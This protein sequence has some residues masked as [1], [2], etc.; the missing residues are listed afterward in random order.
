M[1]ILSKSLFW[2]TA[3]LLLAGCSDKHGATPA[4][5]STAGAATQSARDIRM[6]GMMVAIFG[7]QFRAASNDA[8]AQMPDPENRQRSRSFVIKPITSSTL[9]GGETVLV[10]SGAV[11]DEQGNPEVAHAIG[12]LLSIYFLRSVEGAW[13]VTRKLENI[14]SLGSYGSIG[15]VQ[16]T[17]LGQ[18][19]TGMV[20]LNSGSGQGE[21]VTFMSIFDLTAKDIH[22]LA[23]DPIKLQSSN[24]GDCA[25]ERA[26]CWHVSGAWSFEPGDDPDAYADLVIHFTGKRTVTTSAAASQPATAEVTDIDETARYVFDGHTYRLAVGTNPVPE[27]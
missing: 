23:A 14:A 26:Q 13:Q 10:T 12:G 22:D 11:A 2:I 18:N 1:S 27:I 9:S 19:K 21:S 20:I 6:Q 24:E 7:K 8:L 15:S 17:P 25:P 16:W 5:G 4:T 3:T